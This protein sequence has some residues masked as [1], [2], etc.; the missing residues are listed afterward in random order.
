[1]SFF[2]EVAAQQGGDLVRYDDYRTGIRYEY[3]VRAKKLFRLS[4]S[5]DAEAFKSM[6]DVFRAIF[7]GDATVGE[8]FA[9]LS[10]A[11]QKK[12]TINEAGRR[13]IEYELELKRGDITD[14]A[15]AVIRVDPEKMLPVS[16]A[17]TAGTEKWESAIDYPDEGPADIYAL[18]VS[19]DLPV[20][21]RLPADDLKRILKAVDQGRH[22]LDNY[23]A[24][25]AK[26][27]NY[28]PTLVW[29]KGDKW[30]IDVCQLTGRNYFPTIAP[31]TDMAKWWRSRR[32]LFYTMPY[33]VCDGHRID[34]CGIE[35]KDGKPASSG[36][37]FVE[38]VSGR[39]NTG[40]SSQCDS[41][42]HLVELSAYPGNLSTKV[43]AFSS[44]YT[45]HLDPHGENGPPGT[46][47]METT[48]ANQYWLDPQHGYAAVKYELKYA[49]SNSPAVGED[50][51]LKRNGET[52]EY[53]GYRQSPR[54]VW[55][56]TIV[57]WKNAGASPKD[58][59][60]K[61]T[62][63]DQVTHFYLDF[64]APLPDELFTRTAQT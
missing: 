51:L 44:R 27:P 1:M 48:F 7:R 15:V 16:L 55:Y 11:K 39:D 17:I 26:S 35:M 12:R 6:A 61:V 23:F 28:F 52:Y 64:D 3:D 53:E 37:K 38:N 19:R 47:R 33:L 54:G 25:V 49:V 14:S 22:D 36:W 18:G 46:V 41:E 32:K 43:A 21:D 24:V 59:H 45:I 40:E 62:F 60:G 20:D 10:I 8:Q 56:P 57:R 9:E 2:R 4:T 34:R 50:P 29:R 31:G 58:E 5:R 13:W 63:Q 30:R 42:R